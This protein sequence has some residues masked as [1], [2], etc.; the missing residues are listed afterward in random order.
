VDTQG[1]SHAAA[2]YFGLQGFE[3]EDVEILPQP[4]VAKPAR[5]VKVVT[6]RDLR[7]YHQCR[8]CRRRHQQGAFQESVPIMF[9]DSSL[10]D[11]V[12]MLKVYP[13]RVRCCGGTS[14]EA[15]P[16]E[17][18]GFRTTT[19]FFERIAALCTR[20]T[21]HEVA[22]M[23]EL[24]WNTVF[25]MDKKAIELALGGQQPDLDG[26]RKIGVDEV[27]RTG[28]RRFFT[29][30][31]DLESGRVIHI[32]DG[33]G[34]AAIQEF[35]DRLGPLRA[36]KIRVTASDLGYLKKLQDA[37]P[38]AVHVLDRFHTVKWMN[39]A[40]NE[41]RREVFGGAP[42]TEAGKTMKA[43]QWML[44]SGREN[45]EHGDKLHLKKLMD[46]NQPLFQAYLLKEELRSI[47]RHSWTYLGALRARLETW[48]TATIESNLEKLVIV[49][50]RVRKNA[51]AI[52]AGYKEKVRQGLVEGT[53]SKI[54]RL[55]VQARGYRDKDYF[56]LKIF[57]KCS[58]PK[59][60]WAEIVL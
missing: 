49:G 2:V 39:D 3:V 48:C 24:S 60:P 31:T 32:G 52:I 17:Q 25:R 36:K 46:L 50:K 43:K 6:V 9:R 18:V 33:K 35:V 40:V 8:K 41:V 23:A 11:Y 28:G 45:L 22:Q 15:L 51:E 7:D 42:D 59:N 38:N 4:T 47:L 54:Q 56:K 5:K 19:R 55:R 30:I 57:Q 13:W 29:I 58:L 12:T 27:S 16:F 20:A 21:V 34:K 14:R 10:G 26:V 37:F 1:S 53:N 44:L